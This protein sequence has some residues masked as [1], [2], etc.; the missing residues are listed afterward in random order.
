MVYKIPDLKEEPKLRNFKNFLKLPLRKNARFVPKISLFED[1]LYLENLE[2][3]NTL[4]H[5]N[6]NRN[7]NRNLNLDFSYFETPKSKFS[8]KVE[9]IILDTFGKNTDS[10]LIKIENNN[11]VRKK[12][13]EKVGKLLNKNFD[14][15]DMNEIKNEQLFTNY[16]RYFEIRVYFFIKI[17]KSH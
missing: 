4:S 8:K 1:S 11:N 10:A 15:D 9:E 12:W 7:R 14:L 2:G 6:T 3:D 16:E 5:K 13:S 17:L